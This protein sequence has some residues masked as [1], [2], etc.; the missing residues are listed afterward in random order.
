MVDSHSNATSLRG[1]ATDYGTD[2]AGLVGFLIR[3]FRVPA[4]LLHSV[5][6]RAEF[7]ARSSFNSHG[8]Y[9][10]YIQ[11]LQVISAITSGYHPIINSRTSDGMWC[12]SHHA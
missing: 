12:S 10:Y 7:V 4:E 2:V 3:P 9:S 5:K 8:V 6:Q 1:T 11:N